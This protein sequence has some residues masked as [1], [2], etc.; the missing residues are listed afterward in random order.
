MTYKLLIVEDDPFISRS[1]KAAL[2]EKPFTCTGIAK[3]VDKA[4]ALIKENKPDV[5]LLDIQL[6]GYVEGTA[7]ALYLDT[8]QIP[9]VY[10]TAQTD[11]ETLAAVGKTNPLGY[12]VKPFQDKK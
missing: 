10:L 2:I 7:L 6:K 5:C 9:Y 4:K 8:L 12:I 11:P 3:S 1:I